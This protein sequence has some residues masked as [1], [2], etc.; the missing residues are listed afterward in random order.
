MRRARA[1][2]LF[3]AGYGVMAAF[4]GGAATAA[5]L[6]AFVSGSALLVHDS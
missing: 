6:A 5:E 4:G 3:A 2:V 1:L